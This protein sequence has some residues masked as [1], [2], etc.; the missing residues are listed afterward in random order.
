M[1]GSTD[2]QP[3]VRLRGVCKQFGGVAAVHPLDLTINR[4]DFLAIL[5]PSGCGK[6]T[7]LNIISGFLFPDAGSIE[8]A[9][10]DVT[11]VPPER[12]ET[13][14]V[15]Q[16]YGLF[17]H[18]T[19]EQNIA[20]G[21]RV[22]GAPHDECKQRVAEMVALVH[23]DGLERRNVTGLSGGQQQ[24]VALA[25]ALIMR[26]K[27]LL[28]D[29]PLAALDLQLRKAMQIELRRIHRSIGGTFVFV[30]HDQ[31]EAMALANR[32]AVMQGGR[33][34]QEGTPRQIY[35]APSTRFVSTFIGDA[36]L[37]RGDARGGRVTLAAGP[38]FPHAGADGPVVSVVRP[39]QVQIGPSAA[40]GAAAGQV[41]LSGVVQDI[42]Y[43]GTYVRFAVQVEGA[44]LI[45]H[46][47]SGRAAP[48]VDIGDQ[49][50]VWW[51]VADQL[52]LPDE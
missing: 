48:N 30:T 45:V 2:Q 43:V 7:L 28:L 22:A 17:P 15:F 21:M 24:R 3:L 42:I 35:D 52:V 13:N 11:R 27:V 46:A 23:L 4:G 12:R 34:V 26:P 38:G 8:I 16:S 25:R 29:E 51:S 50:A 41:L 6:T 39:E 20:Y 5:G 47:G 14:M 32:I 40:T 37:L 31:G 10:L 9:G 44:E 18:M 49:V 19:V 33:V 1:S 36:N